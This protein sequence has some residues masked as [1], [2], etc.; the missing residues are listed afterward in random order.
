MLESPRFAVVP[1]RYETF[2]VAVSEALACGLPVVATAVGALPER[3]GDANGLLCPPGDPA[4]LA[5]AIGRML[6][7]HRDYDRAAI[8]AEGYA[9]GRI[10][11]QPAPSDCVEILACRHRGFRRAAPGLVGRDDEDEIKRHVA[12]TRAVFDRHVA[13]ARA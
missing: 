5:D 7:R 4:A 9:V 6:A 2:S 10:G 13:K 3:I 12:R 8:A 1:S 11:G